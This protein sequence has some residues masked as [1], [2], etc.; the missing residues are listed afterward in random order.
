MS[1]ASISLSIWN[2]VSIKKSAS[3]SDKPV[4]ALRFLFLFPIFQVTS[5]STKKSCFN[6]VF[7][8]SCWNTAE[9][10]RLCFWRFLFL[11]AVIFCTSSLLF[12]L[13]VLH[14][15]SQCPLAWAHRHRL[16]GWN[17]TLSPAEQQQQK[18]EPGARDKDSKCCCEFSPFI[19]TKTQGVTA[20]W[21][22]WQLNYRSIKNPSAFAGLI[23][24]FIFSLA[25][26]EGRLP[27]SLLFPVPAGWICKEKPRCGVGKEQSPHLHTHSCSRAELQERAGS[28]AAGR[29][30]GLIP[31]YV[32]AL[33]GG[34]RVV[35]QARG[36]STTRGCC[37][38]PGS[39]FW[40]KQTSLLY[41]MEF[42]N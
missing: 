23:V 34:K 40:G 41:F 36:S 7:W 6:R 18:G 12:S 1:E 19:C 15:P 4:W 16:L 25:H 27:A 29:E 42:H 10:F 20:S 26:R 35:V 24:G 39:L 21:L 9:V 17:K 30:L 5:S 22:V 38:A 3:H 37:S 13:S 8:D 14:N 33:A 28:L 31:G 11:V 2:S 32:T